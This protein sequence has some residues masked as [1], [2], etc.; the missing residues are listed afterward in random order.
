VWSRLA[1]PV[2]V[3]AL[4]SSLALREML[5][6]F[7]TREAAEA[8]LREILENERDWERSCASCRSTSTVAR[9]RRTSKSS[10][11]QRADWFWAS[12]WLRAF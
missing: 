5:D 3:Y 4:P 7:L 11:G 10:W 9:C 2:Q 6:L 12:S 8:E 1:A